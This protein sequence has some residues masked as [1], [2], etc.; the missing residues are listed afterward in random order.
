MHIFGCH[1][2]HTGNKL[3]RYFASAS[4][5]RK[6]RIFAVTLALEFSEVIRLGST[7][8]EQRKDMLVSIDIVWSD[9]IR[10]FVT[11]KQH[12]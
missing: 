10:Q 12:S 4:A 7:L 11:H 6:Y 1:L 3:M 9:Y 2:L 8:R 5:Y